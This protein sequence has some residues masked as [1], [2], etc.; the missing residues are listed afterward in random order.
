M[1]SVDDALSSLVARAATTLKK[2]RLDALRI[3][4]E[5]VK[6]KLRQAERALVNIKQIT[7]G[8]IGAVPDSERELEIAFMIDAYFAFTRAA[9]DVMGQWVNQ[10]SELGLDERSAAFKAVADALDKQPGSSALAAVLRQI[11]KS[12]YFCQLDDYRNCCLHRRSICVRSQSTKS[13]L[14]AGYRTTAPVVHELFELCDDPLALNAKF[15]RQLEVSSYC[16]SMLVH[17]EKHMVRI[18]K[19]YTDVIWK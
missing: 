16:E 3:Y 8:S 17:V 11:R 1:K 15:V 4:S 12:N 5:G 7:Q 19:E 10:A 9:Y 2:R 6:D 18:C 13:K 14:T